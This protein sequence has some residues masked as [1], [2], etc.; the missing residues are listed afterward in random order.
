MHRVL[1]EGRIFPHRRKRRQGFTL[2]ELMVVISIIALLISILLP[3]LQSARRNAR[4]VYC[5][6]NSRQIGAAMRMYADD[7]RGYLPP[8]AYDT[9]TVSA[10]EKWWTRLL[11]DGQY[12]P[13]GQ[14]RPMDPAFGPYFVDGVWRCP[15]VNDDQAMQNTATP[16]LSGRGGGYGPNAS[17]VCVALNVNNPLLGAR[18]PLR[19]DDIRRPTQI[20]LVG[21]V[22]RPGIGSTWSYFFVN[23][24]K[25]PFDRVNALPGS[26][27]PWLRH[28]EICNATF[29][30]N[31]VAPLNAQQL[32]TNEGDIFALISK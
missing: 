23:A 4:T 28:G 7:H 25:P 30:D 12:L 20:W 19:L 15:E 16:A 14:R 10:N 13:D 17:R 21:D 1:A 11:A 5:A 3:A 9:T 22:G 26:F 2:I 32:D 8:F 24:T 18:G 27:Q 31:H 29:I 6:S